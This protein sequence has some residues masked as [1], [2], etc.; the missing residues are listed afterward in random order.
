MG[1]LPIRSSFLVNGSAG[2][3]IIQLAGRVRRHREQVCESPNIL[4]LDTNLKH[5]EQPGKPAFHKPGFETDLQWRLSSHSLSELLTED[6]YKVIDART[7]VL[8]RE[9][10]APGSWDRRAAAFP[11]WYRSALLKIAQSH[12]EHPS[13]DYFP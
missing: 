7:R 11:P 12:F 4:L 2:R 1:V 5:W 9:T 8:A 3:S 6:E 13:A 10:L